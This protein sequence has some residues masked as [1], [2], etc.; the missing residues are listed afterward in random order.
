MLCKC[1][2]IHA[3]AAFGWLQSSFEGEE[4]SIA[5]NVLGGYSKGDGALS[6]VDVFVDL[7]QDPEA[8]FHPSKFIGLQCV[9]IETSIF[10]THSRN[11]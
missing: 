9:H 3:I 2:V 4:R 8:T 11:G 6:T 5:H 7:V 1:V 10:Y